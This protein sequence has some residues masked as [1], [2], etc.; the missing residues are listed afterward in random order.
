LNNKQPSN[1]NSYLS[2][3]SQG[4]QGNGSDFDHAKRFIERAENVFERT[5]M[6]QEEY[7]RMQQEQRKQQFLGGPY[8]EPEDEDSSS[9]DSMTEFLREEYHNRY[10]GNIEIDDEGGEAF[11]ETDS[12]SDY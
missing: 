6:T 7:S 12:D 1:N 2:S 4:S 10:S 8:Y 3:P 11:R 5:K 9:V